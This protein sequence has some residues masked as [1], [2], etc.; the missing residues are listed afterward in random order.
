MLRLRPL[1]SL[2]AAASPWFASADI[3][4]HLRLEPGSRTFMVVM[5]ATATDSQTTFRIPAWSP[6]F[7]QIRKFQDSISGVTARDDKGAE[8][9][10]TTPDVRSW[11]VSAPTGTHIRFGYRVKGDDGGLGFFGSMLDTKSG[12]IN[13]ASAF[14]YIDGR[15]TEPDKLDL[16]L[17]DGWDVATSM[18]KDGDMY[19]A[20]SGYDEFIDNPIQMGNFVRRKFTVEGIPFEAVYVSNGKLASNPD[21]ETERLRK[22][23]A[24]AIQMFH[25]AGFKHYLYI[26]HLAVG[27]FAGGLEHRAS[28]CI[29]IPNSRQLN[30]DDLAA[31]EN[32]HSW[33][34]KQIRPYVLGPFDY[35]QP[36]R[37]GNLWWMEG[38][39]DYYSKLMTYRSGLQDKDWLLG[40]IRD[41]IQD[42]QGVDSR[43]QITLEQCSRDCWDSDGFGYKGLSYYS[44]GFLVG[45]VLDAAIRS[46]TDGKKSLDD[47]IRLMFAKYRLPQPGVP[48][49]GIL[50]AIN[51]VVGT[52]SLT[53]LY[54]EL[55]E[56][57]DEI[58]YSVLRNLGLE[59]LLGA[60][61]H[62]VPAYQ[63]TDGLVSAVTP[64]ARDAG[65]RIGD[66]LVSNDDRP[67]D[68]V[69]D[70]PTTFSVTVERQG[71]K[72]QLD[73]PYATEMGRRADLI[74]DLAPGARAT[75][76]RDL[77]LQR[78]NSA[79]KDAEKAGVGD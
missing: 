16:K 37:T 72:T 61:P 5:D 28:T 44:K 43:N 10:I 24:P 8:L 42:V 65:L 46:E 62:V 63:V 19:A 66:K 41:Q 3:Q 48:E 68:G 64:A 23:S 74:W 36:C 67:W 17:P 59:T 32:F 34:V 9:S 40:Q 13:G 18:D 49:D 56:S 79:A 7:Y 60:Q 75:R 21:R 35:T 73:I 22:V 11:T 54:K 77:W 30:L 51:E 53:P 70:V 58:P 39:T 4:Y 38:V 57:T 14:M 27:D 78:P 76:L 50:A 29:A 69:G 25:G 47:V 45:A 31:H 15:K 1:L 33:N 2:L 6:G 20:S 71:T 26:I 52:S 55:T 12:F